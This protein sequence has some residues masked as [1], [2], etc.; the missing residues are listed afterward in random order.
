MLNMGWNRDGMIFIG[1]RSSKST[2]GATNKNGY[3]ILCQELRI[4]VTISFI[5]TS[6][7]TKM[8]PCQQRHFPS[9]L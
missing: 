5:G 3:L 4:I 1:H 7:C 2:F 8:Y 9:A 6:Q